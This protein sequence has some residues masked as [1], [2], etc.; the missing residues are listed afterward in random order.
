MYNYL[1]VDHDYYLLVILLISNV[2]Q[3]M[4]VF[5]TR[6]IFCIYLE[7]G[8]CQVLYLAFLY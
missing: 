4:Y 3:N 5:I 8:A 1:D 2:L 7:A 6:H